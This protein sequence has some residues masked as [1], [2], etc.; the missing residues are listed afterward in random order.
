MDENL[1]FC[2]HR[3]LSHRYG[4]SQDTISTAENFFLHHDTNNTGFLEI[5]DKKKKIKKKKERVNVL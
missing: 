1:S 5:G 2:T 4:C 3:E